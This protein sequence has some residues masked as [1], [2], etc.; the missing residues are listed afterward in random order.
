M[1]EAGRQIREVTELLGGLPPGALTW[2]PNEGKW[3]VAGHLT[4]LSML[5][6]TY[7]S[8]MEERIRRAREDGGP[9]SDGPYRH[10]RFGSWFARSMEPPPK[11]R[12][13]TMRAMVPDP[14]AV[15]GDVLGRFSAAQHSLIVA[16]DHAQG[17]DLGRIR[18]GSPYQVLI[19]LSL[20]VA[21]ELLLAHDRRHIWLVREVLAW[22]GFPGGSRSVADDETGPVGRGR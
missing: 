19:R 1:I 6:E 16:M 15:S 3:S 10:P 20:G 9:V 13:K 17:L 21:F 7:V 4:H 22:E 14:V 5:N 11:R 2:Q 8:V 18:F 12:F